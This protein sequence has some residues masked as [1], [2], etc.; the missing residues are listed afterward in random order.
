YCPDGIAKCKEPRQVAAWYNLVG[1]ILHYKYRLAS[2]S[3]YYQT[4]IKLDPEFAIARSNYAE[5]LIEM[6]E[7]KLAES[8]FRKA[9]KLD[10]RLAAAH[11]NLAGHLRAK[12]RGSDAQIEIAYAMAEFRK[13]VGSNPGSV[14]S[15]INFANALLS[16]IR[17][18]KDRL[19]AERM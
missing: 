16:V 5:L 7:K 3:N 9:I 14:N 4:A 18:E 19:R 6:N 8:E 11:F 12:G 2:A 1:S 17:Y 15:R 10:P 13:A